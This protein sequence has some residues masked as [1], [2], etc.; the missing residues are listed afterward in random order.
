M[1]WKLTPLNKEIN[2]EGFYSF[3]YAEKGKSFRFLGESH[4]F[5]EIVY[6]DSGEAYV[7]AGSTGYVLKQGYM[8]FHKPME[9]HSLAANQSKPFN[10]LVASFKCDSPAMSF[11]EERVVILNTFQKKLLS[12]FMEKMKTG[13]NPPC[14]NADYQIAASTLERLFLDLKENASAPVKPSKKNVDY[15]FS[16]IIKNY[17]ETNIYK[18]ITIADICKQFNMS[19]SYICQIF[20]DEIGRSIIDYFI[21]LKISKAKLLIRQGELNFTQ[22]AELLGYN[23]IHHFSRAFKSKTGLSPRTYAKSIN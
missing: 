14:S 3:F 8:I 19:K 15:T 22:I 1:E 2:I 20:K 6:V 11:F 5:W 9:Y 10:V 4:N 23:S 7:A 16:Q 12:S 21:E 17:L 18:N 13:Y